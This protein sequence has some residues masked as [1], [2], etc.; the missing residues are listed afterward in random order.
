MGEEVAA[1]AVILLHGLGRT[2]RSMA[3]LGRH[4][5]A[6]GYR[7]ANW[8]Y[9]SAA[10]TFQEHA[11]AL[12]RIARALDDDPALARIHFVTHSLG[13]IVVRF[14]L[15]HFALR[16]QGRVVMLAPPNR[17]SR[18]ARLLA[19]VVGRLVRPLGQLSDDPESDVNRL[20]PLPGGAEVGVIAARGDGKV[21]VAD[22]HV[23]G[24]RDHL[25]VPGWHTF[26]MDRVDVKDAVVR[27]LRG[28]R[29]GER[30]S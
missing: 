1:E 6:A 7:V 26:L 4:L 29:F 27:F 14:G 12:R 13:G 23:E 20:P 10:A 2:A 24:E 18:L 22:T 25:V 17:G 16:K 28:G 11:D 8:D 15:S 5:E 30:T 21:R 3:G 19:P 9:R